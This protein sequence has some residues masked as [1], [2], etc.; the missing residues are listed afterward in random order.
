MTRKTTGCI[1]GDI[2]GPLSFVVSPQHRF[3]ARGEVSITELGME[4]FIA[5]NVLSPYRAR[6]CASFNIIRSR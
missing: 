4:T 2:Y 5:H 1:H 3:A 6:S